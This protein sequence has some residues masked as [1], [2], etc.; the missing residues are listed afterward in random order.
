[1][2]EKRGIEFFYDLSCPWSY[3]ASVRLK[4]VASAIKLPLYAGQ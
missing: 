4:E 1:M 3:L 2:T